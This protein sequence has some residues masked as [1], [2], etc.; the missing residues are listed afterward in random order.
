MTE[1][2]TQITGLWLWFES[3]PSNLTNHF[4]LHKVLRWGPS[5]VLHAYNS[6]HSGGRGKGG[7]QSGL[8]KSPRPYL[9]N[10]LK[11]K[12]TGAQYLLNKCKALSS[13]LC[14]SN[15]SITDP[16]QNQ[17]LVSFSWESSG[18]KDC[19]D[20]GITPWCPCA[21]SQRSHKQEKREYKMAV[22]SHYS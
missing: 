1:E 9:K 5:G 8:G 21:P 7:S 11:C 12:R 22:N 18:Q 20:W 17:T 14:T 2:L 10:K 16:W 19:W 4:Y 13:N 6:R 15:H 3:E